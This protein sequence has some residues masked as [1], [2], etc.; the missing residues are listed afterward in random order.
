[1]TLPKYT[2][3]VSYLPCREYDLT[4]ETSA[5]K[6]P[7]SSDIR[8]TYIDEVGF[9]SDTDP[10][11][12]LMLQNSQSM[13]ANQYRDRLESW[14]SVSSKRTAYFSTTDSQYQSVNDEHDP[15]NVCMFGPPSSL[16]S[17]I[18]PVPDDW[19]VIEDEF[20]MVH[21]TYQT[22][23]SLDCYFSPA[24]KL[25]DGIIWLLVMKGGVSRAELTTFLIKMSDGTHLPQTPNANIQMIACQAFRLEPSDNKGIITVDGE[26]I[27][28][29][30]VQGEIVPSI[31][32]VVVPQPKY[33]PK[34]E[35]L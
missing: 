24:S 19:I 33:I 28:C 12:M 16:P 27:K 3:K 30:P 17:L 5:Y 21:A 6:L 26:Q 35:K 32:K 11:E 22:H 10:N 18:S 34:K 15:N 9:D 8:Q 23:L 1:M 29:G 2:G 31:I 7:S 25:N 13:H 14:Y 4:P 20:V